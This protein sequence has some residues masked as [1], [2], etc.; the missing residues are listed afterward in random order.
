MAKRK[1][2]ALARDPFR[3]REDDQTAVRNARGKVAGYVVP[4]ASGSY[5]SHSLNDGITHSSRIRMHGVTFV[6]GKS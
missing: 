6:L 3:T 2:S 5:F 1:K 4:Q